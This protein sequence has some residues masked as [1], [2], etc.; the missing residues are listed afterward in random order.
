MA[1]KTWYALDSGGG[2]VFMSETSPGAE[3]YDTGP[4]GWVVSTGAGPDY[5]SFAAGVEKAAA[6]FGATAQPDGSL[7]TA[8]VDYIVTDAPYTG[9]FAS[10]NWTIDFA[11][12]AQTNGG[13]HDGRARFRLFRMS[14]QNGGGTN[15]EITAG[16]QLGSSVTN[17]ATSATQKSSVTF[18]PGSFSVTNEYIGIQIGWERQ[19]AGGMTSSDVNIRI[20]TGATVVTSADFTAGAT[21]I[22]ADAAAAGAATTSGVSGATAKVDGAATAA[23]TATGVGAAVNLATGAA[24]AAATTSG[25]GATVLPAVGAAAGAAST[26]GTAQAIVAA[27]A[28]SAGVATAQAEGED[29]GS[30]T[31]IVEADASATASA[32]AQAIGAAFAV[33]EAAAAGQAT[34]LADGQ[35]IGAPAA[36]AVQPSGGWEFFRRRVRK[37]KPEEALQIIVEDGT[38]R[39]KERA[40]R[41]ETEKLL[42]R[43]SRGERLLQAEQLKRIQAEARWAISVATRIQR[44]R[45]DEEAVALA[46]L[47][48]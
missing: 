31:T 35:D 4:T 16:V 40:A 5:S 23:A 10:G 43:V 2:F 20:G 39:E 30:G 1:A 8:N 38:E 44:E 9:T 21:T 28:A 11:V 18:N 46:L 17:L 36:V 34:G 14:L 33:A 13:A 48:D 7:D 32:T 12:R 3:A 27:V 37:V 47:L 29:I 19:G 26:S 42:A 45:D 24:T 25:I 6:T 22:E 15:V 41:L